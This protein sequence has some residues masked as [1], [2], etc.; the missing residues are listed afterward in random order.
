VYFVVRKTILELEH[1]ILTT[2]FLPV[3]KTPTLGMPP[4]RDI[5]FVI[6]LI[7][8]TAPIYESL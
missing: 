3:Q 4:N 7:P 1:A 2:M 5:E 8:G 6:D